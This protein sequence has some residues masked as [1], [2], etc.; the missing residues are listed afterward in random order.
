[1]SVLRRFNG[2]DWVAVAGPT[3][4]VTYQ[5]GP[6]S[7][8]PPASADITGKLFWALDEQVMY[9]C[10]G[11]EWQEIVLGNVVLDDDSRLSDERTPLDNSVTTAKLSGTVTGNAGDFVALDGSGGFQGVDSGA[12]V[13][14][15]ALADGSALAG[16]AEQVDTLATSGTV[17]IDLAAA[18]VFFI[19]PTG[20]ATIEFT[21]LPSSGVA[22]PFTIV[23]NND[24]HAILWPFGTL[25][26]NGQAPELDGIT[27]LSGVAF[28][29]E[30]IISR[31]WGGVA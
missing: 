29:G 23:V 16:Y 11:S 21:G 4:T 2:T 8:R 22:R 10:D 3:N 27:F 30:I 5:Q 13:T 24:D 19:D 12:Y 15:D 26:P 25:F 1:M 7:S 9:Y 6:I 31:A 28:E 14:S 20:V 18:N 17:T